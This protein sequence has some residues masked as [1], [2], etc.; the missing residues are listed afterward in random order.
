[1]QLEAAQV[2]GALSGTLMELLNFQSRHQFGTYLGAS[3]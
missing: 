2:K 3:P 1:M